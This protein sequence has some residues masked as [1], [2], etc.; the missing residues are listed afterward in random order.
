MAVPLRTDRPIPRWLALPGGLLLLGGCVSSPGPETAGG[1]R[2]QDAGLGW[3]VGQ[4]WDEAIMKRL[5]Q[6][7]GAGLLNPIDPSTSVRHDKR[8]DRLRV[9]IDAGN[10]ITAARCE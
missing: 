3:A 9:Y 2:C 4:P 7:S 1:G 5:W 6:E 8:D 10:R